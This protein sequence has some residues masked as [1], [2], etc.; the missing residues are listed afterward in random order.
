MSKKT[1]KDLAAD[2]DVLKEEL[3]LMSNMYD[4][5]YE[6]YDTQM[7][8]CTK[9]SHSKYV[10]KQ[11]IGNRRWNRKVGINYTI[12][13]YMRQYEQDITNENG[14]TWSIVP[15]KLQLKN[16]LIGL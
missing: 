3:K 4:G 8:L 1:I 12:L 15:A 2:F 11:S 14:K 6:K 13:T 10:Y 9:I 5:L 7:V 16:I